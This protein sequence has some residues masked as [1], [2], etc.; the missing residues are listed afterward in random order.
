MICNS[1]REATLLH[2][3]QIPAIPAY[4]CKFL[5]FLQI[6]AKKSCKFLHF[7]VVAGISIYILM[8]N[9]QTKQISAITYS[10]SI[11]LHWISF[12][13]VY[14]M[15]NKFEFK[16]YKDFFLSNFGLRKNILG[17]ILMSQNLACCIPFERKFNVD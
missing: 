16:F 7:S 15:Y 13:L 2:F 11:I 5:Q 3:L 1:S 12:Q 6:P 17:K 14:N 10:T 4:S 9:I 8:T